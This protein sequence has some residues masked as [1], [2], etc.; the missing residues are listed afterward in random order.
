[1]REGEQEFI[2]MGLVVLNIGK[3]FGGGAIVT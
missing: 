2:S 3:K 1:M